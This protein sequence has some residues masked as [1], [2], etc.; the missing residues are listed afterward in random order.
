[1][2]EKD[3]SLAG[4]IEA[5]FEDLEPLMDFRDWLVG[6]R[7]EP[8][9]R[10]SV[11]RNGQAHYKADGALIPGPFTIAARRKI[12]KKLRETQ[13]LVGRKLI[14]DDEVSLIQRIW[15]DDVMRTLDSRAAQWARIGESALAS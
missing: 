11:R 15:V 12:L 14:S 2:V 7:N 13:E 8:K 9:F 6:I 1:M 5:G 4:M 10:M 3:R